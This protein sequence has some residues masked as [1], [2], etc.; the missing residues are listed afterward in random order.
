MSPEIG[1]FGIALAVLITASIIFAFYLGK[2]VQKSQMYTQQ[3]LDEEIAV[4]LEDGY[5]EGREAGYRE[6]TFDLAADGWET[7]SSSSV[8]DYE[9]GVEA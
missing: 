8:F 2:E 4:A 5:N 1:I 9:E 3:E 7:E 6:A